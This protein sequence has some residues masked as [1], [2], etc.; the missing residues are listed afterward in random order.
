MSRRLPSTVR[1]FLTHSGGLAALGLTAVLAMAV[2]PAPVD[3]L[4]DADPVP[5]EAAPRLIVASPTET[6]YEAVAKDVARD[7][8]FMT[9]VEGYAVNSNFGMRRH[10]VSGQMKPHKGVDIAAPT[11]ASV[12]ASAAGVVLRTGYQPSGFGNFVEVRHPNGLTTVYAHLS[13][14]EVVQGEPVT[15]GEELGKVGSTGLSTGPHLHFEVRKDGVQM[16]PMRVLNRVFQ[17]LG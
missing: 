7:V 9:P 1:S 12:E 17:A 15:Q 4:A 16:N 5:I 11:G 14:V 13:R 10:P 3:D 8:A 6:P 2:A